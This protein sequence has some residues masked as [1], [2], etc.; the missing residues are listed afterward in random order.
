MWYH[1]GMTLRSVYE[2]RETM[3]RC[4]GCG[5]G[6]NDSVGHRSMLKMVVVA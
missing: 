4:E 1:P 6:V 3:L 5:E 2:N